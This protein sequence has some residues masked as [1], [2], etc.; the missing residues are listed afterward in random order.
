MA[1]GLLPSVNEEITET[2]SN[3]SLIFGDMQSNSSITSN[4]PHSAEEYEGAV[5]EQE[6][7]KELEYEQE[8]QEHEHWYE[9]SEEVSNDGE[10]DSQET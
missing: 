10:S 4:I 3:S 7:D 2:S 1:S 8:E 6:A 5:E 9:Q